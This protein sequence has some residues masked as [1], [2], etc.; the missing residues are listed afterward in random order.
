MSKKKK[1]IF[2]ANNLMMFETADGLKYYDLIEGKGP[3]AE[4]GSTVQVC[5][6]HSFF[7]W[8]LIAIVFFLG[9]GSGWNTQFI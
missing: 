4:K 6:E 3:T 7:M 2:V 1:E 5:V 8:N 9:N